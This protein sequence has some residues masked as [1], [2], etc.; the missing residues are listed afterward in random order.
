MSKPNFPR[1]LGEAKDAAGRLWPGR[2]APL[3]AWR[4]YHERRAEIFARVAEADSDHH[5]EALHL[6]GVERSDA[7]LIEARI[8]ARDAAKHKNGPQ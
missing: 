5:Y 1:T 8:V 6:A 2:E 4:S 7:Q 3:E